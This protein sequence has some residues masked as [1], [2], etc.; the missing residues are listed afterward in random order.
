MRR[1]PG[2]VGNRVHSGPAGDGHPEAH[3]V[4]QQPQQL[5]VQVGEFLLAPEV[6]DVE[7]PRAQ[8]YRLQVDQQRPV[9]RVDPVIA[10]GTAMDRLP[11]EAGLG[12]LGLDPGVLR[13]QEFPIALFEPG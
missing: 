2:E 10:V 4:A 5:P 3:R 13:E 9:A 1:V 6:G 7:L 8:A 11:L 12:Q